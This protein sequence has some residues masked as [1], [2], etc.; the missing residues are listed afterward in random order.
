M[1]VIKRMCD[2]Y[3]FTPSSMRKAWGYTTALSRHQACGAYLHFRTLME[4]RVPGGKWNEI[5]S[6]LD[7]QFAYGFLDADLAH[8]LAN[9]V[10]PGNLDSIS[11]FRIFGCI[12]LFIARHVVS[13][14]FIS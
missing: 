13:P 1:L 5:K 12:Y 8:V 7:S 2:E 9:E 14:G 10:P 4:K 3:D 6:S 11:A